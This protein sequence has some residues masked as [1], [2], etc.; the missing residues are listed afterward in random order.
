MNSLNDY[1]NKTRFNYGGNAAGLSA[2]SQVKR[3]KPDW[4]AVVFEKGKYVS[5]AGCGMPYHIEG[6][7]P[8][9]EDL[10]E[11]TPEVA[12]QER[13]ID[14]RLNCTV[15]AVDPGKKELRVDTPEG[16]RTEKFDYLLIATGALPITEGIRLEKSNRIFTIKDLTDTKKF[17]VLLKKRNQESVQLSE[18]LYRR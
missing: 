16:M 9:F 10:I 15:T 14:L 2:A 1:D 4:E 18:A 17:S 13:K 7:V 6:I 12:V 8:H 3:L 5:Y 11:L